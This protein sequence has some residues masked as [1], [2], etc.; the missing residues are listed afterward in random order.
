MKN[1]QKKKYNTL[2]NKRNYVRFTFKI[3]QHI[4][5]I[6]ILKRVY[7][8]D[9]ILVHLL[10]KYLHRPPYSLRIDSTPHFSYKNY[11]HFIHI[12]KLKT[13]IIKQSFFSV[14]K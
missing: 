4:Y 12:P 9:I 5:N 8:H 3:Q 13:N 1:I 7:Y 11:E 10:K 2:Q 6:Y 14:Y